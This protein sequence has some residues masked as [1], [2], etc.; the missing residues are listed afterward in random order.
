MVESSPLGRCSFRSGSH[1]TEL[2]FLRE[3]HLKHRESIV[4]LRE[5]AVPSKKL[6]K[7][8]NSSGGSAGHSLRFRYNFI[9]CN[10]FNGRKSGLCH[11]LTR[12]DHSLETTQV[13]TSAGSWGSLP[14]GVGSWQASTSL[15]SLC[16]PALL[17]GLYKLV[18]E[19]ACAPQAPDKF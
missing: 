14:E 7:W 4:L 15:H 8:Y 6:L 11:F 5:L 3:S 17:T 2:H 1:G 19:W 12:N 10:Y 9:S 18:K 13:E 16:P